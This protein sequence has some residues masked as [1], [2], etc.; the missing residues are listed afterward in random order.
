MT[1]DG[2]KARRA[3]LDREGWRCQRCK[4]PG[5]LEAHHIVS[6]YTDISLGFTLSNLEVLC[7]GCHIQHHREE[8]EK[9]HPTDVR[10]KEPWLDFVNELAQDDQETPPLTAQPRADTPS[11]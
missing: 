2:R 1:L 11:G 6:I 7:R 9:T 10:V 4:T 8:K 3:A 5:R